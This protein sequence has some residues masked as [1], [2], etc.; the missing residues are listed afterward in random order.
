M[1]APATVR[2]DVLALLV[3]AAPVLID[4]V[5][6]SATVPLKVKSNIPD[7]PIETARVLSA[8]ALAALSVPVVMVVLPVKVLVPESISG[9]LPFCITP[10]TLEPTTALIVVAPE[11]DPEL[12]IV[13]VLLMLVPEAVVVPELLLLKMTLPVPLMPPDKVKVLVPLLINVLPLA[14]GVIAPLIVKAEVLLA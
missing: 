13:P 14:L 9:E 1:R 11:P 7:A 8:A 6:P 4:K 3:M 10:V 5:E 12:V 2:L